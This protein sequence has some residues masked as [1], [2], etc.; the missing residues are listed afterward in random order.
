MSETPL[1]DESL[2]CHEERAKSISVMLS[3][4]EML[5]RRDGCIAAAWAMEMIEVLVAGSQIKE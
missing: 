1:Y 5:A 4:L 3:D 2:A